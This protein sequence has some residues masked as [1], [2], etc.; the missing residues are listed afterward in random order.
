MSTEWLKIGSAWQDRVPVWERINEMWLYRVQNV[1]C[2]TT[3]DYDL[4]MDISV[5]PL[6]VPIEFYAMYAICKNWV[7][8]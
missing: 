2:L 1:S 8:Q 7:C 5:L 6:C 4:I 3:T